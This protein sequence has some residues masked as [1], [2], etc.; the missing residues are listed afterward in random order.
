MYVLENAF[1]GEDIQKLCRQC[2]GW[3]ETELFENDDA[4]THICQCL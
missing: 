2:S 1:Q 3:A 4:D